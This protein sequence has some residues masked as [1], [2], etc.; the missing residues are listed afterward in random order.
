MKVRSRASMME[1][2]RNAAAIGLWLVLAVAVSGSGPEEEFGGPFSGRVVRD[3]PFSAEART[4]VRQ[5]L[6]DGGQVERIGIARYYRDGAG[7]IRV[8]HVVSGL[9]PLNG[10][11]SGQVR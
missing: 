4:T 10:A 8:E 2:G 9:D 6:P 7:R 3:V 11:A 5:T 1:T